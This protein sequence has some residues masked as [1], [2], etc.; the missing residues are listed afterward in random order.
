M[1]GTG[2]RVGSEDLKVT[3]SPVDEVVFLQV[4][5]ATGNVPGHM[6]KIQHS[7]GGGLVLWEDKRSANEAFVEERWGTG[8]CLGGGSDPFKIQLLCPTTVKEP[9]LWD[10]HDFVYFKAPLVI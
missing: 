9:I 3:G 5:T 2:T 10:R 4:L 7:Q 6:Q 8:F 1:G